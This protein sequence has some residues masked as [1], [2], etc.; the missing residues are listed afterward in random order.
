MRQGHAP[1]VVSRLIERLDDPAQRDLLEFDPWVPR[2][3][4]VFAE[5][6]GGDDPGLHDRAARL[7]AAAQ[8]RAQEARIGAKSAFVKIRHASRRVVGHWQ[9]EPIID[10]MGG[11]TR[12]RDEGID[13]PQ[14]I[15]F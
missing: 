11:E 4:G 3:V 9:T 13:A 2:V 1:G 7:L 5:E 15:C 6:A 8:L 14:P 12:F 10:E